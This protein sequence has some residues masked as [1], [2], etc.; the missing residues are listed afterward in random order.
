MLYPWENTATTS[1]PIICVSKTRTHA[2]ENS[3]LYALA[4]M[5]CHKRMNNK[6]KWPFACLEIYN[7]S[8]KTKLH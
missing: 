5:A 4:T 7:N 1:A 6:R 2:L 3:L 8:S